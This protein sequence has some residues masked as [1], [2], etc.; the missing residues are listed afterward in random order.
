[1]KHIAIIVT[2]G[3]ILGNVEGPRQVF[4]E[5]N[6]FLLNTG[7]SPLFNVNLVG[8]SK[9]SKLNEGLYTIITEP[10]KNVKK[11]DLIIIPAMYGDLRKA[12]EENK[13]FIPWIVKQHEKGTEVASLC[14]GAFLLASTGLL[15]GKSCA[16]HWLAAND[17]RKMFPEVNL[18]EERIMTDENGIYSSGGAYSSLNLILYLVEKYAGRETAVLCSKTFQ[19]DIQRDN[20]SSFM[21]FKGQ[22][23][24]EDDSVMKAQEFIENNYHS[25]ITVDE[26]A[27]MFALSRRNLER[28]F[29]KAT[30]NTVTKYIQRVK[31]EAAKLSLESSKENINE[32]MYNV[33]YQDPK[34][35]RTIFKRITG[36]SPINYRNRYNRKVVIGQL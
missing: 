22:K 8:L 18:V 14:L 9:E 35:F 31:V 13:D 5:V 26:L 25:K 19:I 17:F 15:N 4:S 30:A 11:V 34:A 16:T 27:A 10:F 3:A 29:K 33:G 2:K 24:H 6:Q 36:M 20:Q 21:I 1:M 12:I 23:E 28:R 7:K 32:V